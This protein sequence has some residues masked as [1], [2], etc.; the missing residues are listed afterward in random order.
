MII[1]LITI[2]V[3]IMVCY[4]LYQDKQDKDKY[5]Q[6]HFSKKVG[7]NIPKMPNTPNIPKEKIYLSPK[8]IKKIQKIAVVPKKNLPMNA[9]IDSPVN[10]TDVMKHCPTNTIIIKHRTPNSLSPA[11]NQSL[12]MLWDKYLK[13]DS[14]EADM[15]L[16]DNSLVFLATTND[17]I[18]SETIN[19]TID[20]II[21]EAC[22]LVIDEHDLY[23]FFSKFS[24]L[25]L[26]LSSII[27]YNV[28]VDADY[29]GQGIA[30]QLLWEVE[31]W[32]KANNK[33][34]IILF[35]KS[36]N[37]PALRLYQGFGYVIDKEYFPSAGQKGEEYLMYKCFK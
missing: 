12:R 19:K 20:K 6:S 11:E 36:K 1:F 2:L 33:N 32:A 21:G 4:K 34:K 5:K 23:G 25:R 15:G 31:T 3:F 7:P 16:K 13:A 14:P 22:V 28:C 26:D 10:N 18:I 8:T 24:Q 35:V 17:K 29:R 27:L 30:K 9:P 37:E